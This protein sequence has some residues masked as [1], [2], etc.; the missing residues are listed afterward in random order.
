MLT[1]SNGQLGKCF[2]VHLSEAIERRAMRVSCAVRYV[3]IV[4]PTIL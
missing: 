3:Y 1:I 2:N 4:N